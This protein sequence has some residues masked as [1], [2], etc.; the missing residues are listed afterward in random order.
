[1]F[2]LNMM[3]TVSKAAAA[4]SNKDSKYNDKELVLV[5]NAPL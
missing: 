4:E 2:L 1:M 3:K 5:Q